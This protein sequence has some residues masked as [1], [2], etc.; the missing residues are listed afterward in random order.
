MNPFKMLQEDHENIAE[1]FEKLDATSE[2]AVVERERLFARLQDALEVHTRLEEEA[3]YPVL[4]SRE[5]TR[6]LTLEAVEEHKVARRLL[7]ELAR[8]GKDSEQWAAK[9]TV[10]R[11]NVEHHVEEEEAELFRLARS[12]LSREEIEELAED[13]EIA[14]EDIIATG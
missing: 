5:E 12:I 2:N 11:E 6:G 3:F 14:R 4:E 10:L 9:L 8:M 13:L 1:M 7:A